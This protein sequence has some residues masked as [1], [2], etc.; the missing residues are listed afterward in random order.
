VDMGMNAQAIG[1]ERTY[2]RSLMVGFHAWWSIGSLV[3][4]GIG[5]LTLALGVSSGVHFAGVTVVILVATAVALPWLRM[6]DR[7][8]TTGSQA[9]SR[10]VLALPRGALLPIAIVGFGGALGE[11]L[12][13]DWSGV[14]L[15]DAVGAP[16]AQWGY[17]YVALTIAMTFARLI[18]DRV[19]DRLGPSRTVTAGAW[20]AAVGLLLVATMPSLPTALVGFLLVGLGVGASIPLVFAA[21]GRLA[22][23][24][25]E[26][27]AAVATLTYLA[28]LVG[29]PIVGFMNDL[30]SIRWSMAIGAVAIA[31]A[32]GRPGILP[33]GSADHD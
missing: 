11:G 12:G 7:V 33:N 29:P 10:R 32:A 4:A 1:V 2:R 21:G 30:T 8:E 22:S 28:F 19:T 6:R 3:G 25:G 15:R 14:F 20:L 16:E 23:T 9:P 31:I 13:N 24:P 27:V 17:A 5:A 18:G 26:G